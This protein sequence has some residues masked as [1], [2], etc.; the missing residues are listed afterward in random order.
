MSTIDPD[1]VSQP[2][3]ALTTDS[4]P[5]LSGPIKEFHIHLVSDAT[6]ETVVAAARACVSQFDRV[7]PIE[8]FWN[9]VRNERQLELVIEELDANPGPVL[10]TLVDETL[11]RI[12]E[13]KA[14]ALKVPCIPVLDPIFAA[15]SG[16]LEETKLPRPG[17][18]HN[19][20]AVYFDRIDAMD[21]ALSHDDGQG[22]RDLYEADV[23]LIGVSRTSKTPT[24]LYLANRG[25]KAAN[26]PLVPGAALPEELFDERG[27]MVVG[28]TIDPERLS[29]VRRHRL[30][31]LN[32]STETDYADIE[33]VREE[34][35]EARRLC[36]RHGWSVI[37]VTRRSIEET[38]A[39]IMTRLGRRHVAEVPRTHVVGP[40]FEHGKNSVE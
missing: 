18:Q 22:S 8:H 2:A 34:V 13:D 15:L 32:Q 29:A 35:R 23:V 17:H 39:E 27:P 16:F 6:G 9:L 5:A 4:E 37:D 14:R 12:L 10:Y 26:I 24:C 38:A 25:I 3:G 36:A 40:L 30:R 20:D 21:F 11:R 31:H 28:L 7:L 1:A 33:R 19:L